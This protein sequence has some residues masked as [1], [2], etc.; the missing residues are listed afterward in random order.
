[1]KLPVVTKD[2]TTFSLRVI[3]RGKS[4]FFIRL[5][6][7]GYAVGAVL[8]IPNGMVPNER[9]LGSLRQAWEK[10]ERKLKLSGIN[11]TLV[12]LDD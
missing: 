9:A 8:P 4:E 5:T 12:L 1:M 3:A 6:V 2:G 10:Q 11:T 7:N